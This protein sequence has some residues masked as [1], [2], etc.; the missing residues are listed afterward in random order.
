[1]L[2]LYELFT[3]PAIGLNPQ[4]LVAYLPIP[5]PSSTWAPSVSRTLDSVTSRLCL[6]WLRFSYPHPLS[7]LPLLKPRRPRLCAR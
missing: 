3:N 2:T 4:P 1:M 7:W 6:S 5:D